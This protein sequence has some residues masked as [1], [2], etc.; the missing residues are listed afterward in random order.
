MGDTLEAGAALGQI[1]TLAPSAG[2]SPED[3]AAVTTGL[4][5]AVTTG[6]LTTLDPGKFHDVLSKIH[7]ASPEGRDAVNTVLTYVEDQAAAQAEAQ[8]EGSPYY[9]AFDELRELAEDYKSY[10][11]AGG[12]E[13]LFE[14]LD[15]KGTAGDF[16]K[17][18]EMIIEGPQSSL[19]SSG[20]SGSEMWDALVGT[21]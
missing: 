11:N 8:G 2:I 13:K 21:D 7:S 17:E 15:A 19:D 5:N 3:A 9:K 4:L 1:A 18:L 14:G 12:I 16:L 6:D 20:N 10:L